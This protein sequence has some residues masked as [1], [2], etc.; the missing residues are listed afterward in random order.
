MAARLQS[1][2]MSLS[3]E[4]QVYLSGKILEADRALQGLIDHDIPIDDSVVNEDLLLVY[5]LLTDKHQLRLKSVR[6][7]AYLGRWPKIS[8]GGA[9]Y[10]MG[11]YQRFDEG[12]VESVISWMVSRGHKHK[13]FPAGTDV[14]IPIPDE[15]TI[16]LS[17][18]W[19]TGDWGDA[20]H[21]APS[22]KIRHFIPTLKPHITI[23]LGDVYYSGDEGEVMDNLINIW[24]QGSIGSFALNSNHEMYAEG[25]RAY[26][27]K[28][29][30][31][32]VFR[33]QGG[34]S[35]F[36]LENAGWVIV[37]LD[38]AYFSEFKSLYENGSLAGSAG[39]TAQLEFLKKQATKG[40]KVILLSHHNGLHDNDDG[41]ETPK[42]IWQQVM[43]CFPAG[44]PPVLWYWGHRHN[45][46]VYAPRD[47][48]HCRCAGHGALPWGH[49]T[50]LQSGKDAGNI[51]W[52][53]DRNANDPQVP[54]R[55]LNGF[56]CLE[57]RQ[58]DVAETFYDENGGV[59]WKSV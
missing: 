26:F 3:P 57:I 5:S 1:A 50:L 31:S 4:D 41:T 10:G 43:D 54:V 29:L 56:A 52:F 47:G 28:T 8:K 45:A 36:A 34:Q 40:K 14:V 55:L 58:S 27:E 48:V 15:V 19:G 25:G 53:E 21:P 24:P 13:P 42:P 18:D 12:W 44:S 22:T 59:A 35:F 38:S 7:A 33:L 39:N 6:E 51:D 23:H 17:G 32:D 46:T 30:R 11:D 37:G 16:V 20:A 9:I 49:A 2:W